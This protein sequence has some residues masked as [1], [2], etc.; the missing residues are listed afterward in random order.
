MARCCVA[1]WSVILAS[2]DRGGPIPSSASSPPEL[3][4]VRLC[5]AQIEPCAWPSTRSGGAS[6][7]GLRAGSH[8]SPCAPRGVRA[9]RTPFP[10][11]APALSAP[12]A[13]PRGPAGSPR[14]C[15]ERGVGA[16]TGCQALRG[17]RRRGCTRVCGSSRCQ[18][19][20]SARCISRGARADSATL[21]PHSGVE[22]TGLKANPT[23]K[24][25]YLRCIFGLAICVGLG[26]LA[27]QTPCVC[28]AGSF[29]S[30]SPASPAHFSHQIGH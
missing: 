15:G 22:L 4:P 21:P 1:G 19:R 2:F 27:A 10:H 28:L 11:R 5:Q 7:E 17:R 6:T 23:E 3:F 16:L 24:R 25:S 13:A 26:G 29:R 9:A 8:G 30:R 18:A 20:L 12:H 14:C